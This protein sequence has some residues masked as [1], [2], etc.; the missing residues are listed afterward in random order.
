[1][2][3]RVQNLPQPSPLRGVN[4]SVIISKITEITSDGAVQP[5]GVAI[6][7]LL[8]GFEHPIATEGFDLA[9]GAATVAVEQVAVV[10]L[11]CGLEG[12]V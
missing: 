2:V 12:A 8:T 1:M 3:S 7:T 9:R 11:L 5:H 6:I 10:T 4:H